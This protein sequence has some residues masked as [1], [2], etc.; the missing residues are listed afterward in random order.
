[1]SALKP[2]LAPQRDGGWVFALVR[3]GQ[4]DLARGE[5]GHELGELVYVPGALA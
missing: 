5:I 1:M 4:L 2:S 3:L